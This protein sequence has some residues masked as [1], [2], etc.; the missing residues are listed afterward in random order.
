[1]GQDKCLIVLVSA[2]S[3]QLKL[4]V[5]YLSKSLDSRVITRPPDIVAIPPLNHQDVILLDAEHMDMPSMQAWHPETGANGHTTL[6]A[7]NVMDEEHA[8]SLVTGLQLRG[9][10]YRHNSLEMIC[11]GIETLQSG[12]LWMSRSLMGRMVETCHRQQRSTYRPICGLTTRELQILGLLSAGDSNQEIAQRLFI[13]LH[14][15]KSHLYNIFKKIEVR[16]RIEAVNWA[17]QH[18]GTPPPVDLV[19]KRSETSWEPLT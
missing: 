5:D 11:K 13:S 12:Q 14:T 17:H 7:I 15:V 8:Y 19:A 4:F 6:A 16:N 1:M 3:S 9:I 10:F 2:T 18:L